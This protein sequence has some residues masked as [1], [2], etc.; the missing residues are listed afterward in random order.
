MDAMTAAPLGDANE[1]QPTTVPAVEL[2]ALSDH[3]WR[4]V[5]PNIEPGDADSILGFVEKTTAGYELL[6]L[7]Q[8]HGLGHAFVPTLEDAIAHFRR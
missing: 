3:E 6:I 1:T 2:R 4:I 7:R 8:G 5:N